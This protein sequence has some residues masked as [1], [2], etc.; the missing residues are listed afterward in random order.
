MQKLSD[1]HDTPC[2]R[3]NFLKISVCQVCYLFHTSRKF[4]FKRSF[5]FPKE[6]S[7]PM[8]GEFKFECSYFDDNDKVIPYL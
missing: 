5:S 7:D 4:P 6:S 2:Q 1:Q 3:Q 8:Y